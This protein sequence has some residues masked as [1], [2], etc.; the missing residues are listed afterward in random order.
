VFE[1]RYLSGDHVDGQVASLGR[2][3]CP[4]CGEPL[5]FEEG[6]HMCKSCAYT[7]CGG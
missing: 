3:L 2:E 4:E 7:K 5:V 6:C 1:S